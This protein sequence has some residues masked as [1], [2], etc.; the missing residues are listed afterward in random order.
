MEVTI[1]VVIAAVII[2]VAAEAAAYLAINNPP[3]RLPLG[4][5]PFLSRKRRGG[6]VAAQET[7][8]RPATIVRDPSTI[9]SGFAGGRGRFPEELETPTFFET[10][11]YVH[12]EDVW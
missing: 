12:G 2:V 8:G 11:T 10:H 4:S 7:K 3:S 9:A 6:G 5:R 1:V